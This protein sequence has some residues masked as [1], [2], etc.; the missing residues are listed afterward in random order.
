M[1]LKV[2]PGILVLAIK[3]IRTDV[4][5]VVMFLLDEVTAETIMFQA[6]RTLCW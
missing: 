5:N 3:L 6:D 4:A 1:T 2:T